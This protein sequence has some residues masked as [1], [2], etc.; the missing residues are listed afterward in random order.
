MEAKRSLEICPKKSIGSIEL[1][2]AI[3]VGNYFLVTCQNC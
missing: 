3:A 2:A 1:G